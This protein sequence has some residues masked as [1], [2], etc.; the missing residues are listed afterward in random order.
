MK[1]VKGKHFRPRHAVESS[2]V[3]KPWP[4]PRGG[5]AKFDAI[6]NAKTH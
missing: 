3:L 5:D 2:Y 1:I 6:H 4:F